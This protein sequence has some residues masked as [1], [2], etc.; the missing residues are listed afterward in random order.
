MIANCDECYEGQ[1]QGRN[2]KTLKG[3]I[4][5]IQTAGRV[6]ELASSSVK[7]GDVSI[8]LARLL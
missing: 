7:S 2:A 5:T 6:A 4:Y 3:G 1:N 8:F